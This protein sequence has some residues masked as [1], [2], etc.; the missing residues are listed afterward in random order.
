MNNVGC[1]YQQLYIRRLYIIDIKN[2]IIDTNNAILDIRNCICWYH[3][4]STRR[5]YLQY[6]LLIS[7]IDILDINITIAEGK[8]INY[9]Y[10]QLHCWYQQ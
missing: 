3:V 2:Y 6:D 1:L 10:Q 9:S 8:N 7:I 5:W 4:M